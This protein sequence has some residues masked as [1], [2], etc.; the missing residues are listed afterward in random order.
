VPPPLAV[1]IPAHEAL[2]AVDLALEVQPTL[3][4]AQADALITPLSDA[5]YQAL[6]KCASTLPREGKQATYSVRFQVAEERVVAAA[7]S[8]AF[9]PE[10]SEAVS[11]CLLGALGGRAVKSK[12]KEKLKVTAHVRLTRPEAAVQ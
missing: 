1:H 11:E 12:V 7:P 3:I 8:K 5:V 9:S 2:P 10:S 6:T 4:K